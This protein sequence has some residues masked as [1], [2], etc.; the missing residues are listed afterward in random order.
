MAARCAGFSLLRAPRCNAQVMA[1]GRFVSRGRGSGKAGVQRGAIQ[2][3]HE[4]T[5]T[6]RNAAKA[7]AQDGGVAGAP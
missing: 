3:P 2:F 6:V 1:A 7:R 5:S 4:G